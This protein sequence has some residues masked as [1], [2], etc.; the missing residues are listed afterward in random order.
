MRFLKKKN[1]TNSGKRIFITQAEM[2][3]FLKR[4]RE[5][6]C[7]ELLLREGREMILIPR[8]KELTPQ[9]E[10]ILTQANKLFE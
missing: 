8:E 7:D 1:V 5:I 6:F 2:S 4:L 3:A 9:L 10:E